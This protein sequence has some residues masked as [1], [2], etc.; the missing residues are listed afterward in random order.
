VGRLLRVSDREHHGV[1]ADDGKAVVR[2]RRHAVSMRLRFQ[3]V[4]PIVF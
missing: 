1:H 3:S 2:W 4:Q